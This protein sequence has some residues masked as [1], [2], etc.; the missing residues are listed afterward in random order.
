MGA[1]A[2]GGAASTLGGGGGGGGGGGAG[3]A[4]TFGGGGG[5]GGGSTFFTSATGTGLPATSSFITAFFEHPAA[6]KL[7]ATMETMRIN[8]HD[9]FFSISYL[10]FLYLCVLKI[11]R[12]ISR[13]G[14]IQ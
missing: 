7:T 2:L 8:H 5:G 10:L 4:S 6:K 13:T 3:A 12:E 1:T 14:G 11:Q 9:D